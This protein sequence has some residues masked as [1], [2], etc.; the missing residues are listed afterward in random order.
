[1]RLDP[2]KFGTATAVASALAW[3]ICSLAVWSMPAMLL[4][5]GRNMTH[6]DLS[7]MGWHITPAGVLAGLVAWII[8]TGIFGWLL[9]TI[10]NRLL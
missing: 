4:A 1:M 7:Q 6:M 5:M 2:L 8:I 10:Y 3:L 9:A